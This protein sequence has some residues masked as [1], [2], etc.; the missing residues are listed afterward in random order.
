MEPSVESLEAAGQNGETRDG[1]SGQT[2]SSF[3]QYD[4]SETEYYGGEFE[5]YAPVMSPD[6]E[7]YL[8]KN[9]SLDEMAET[10]VDPESLYSITS[11]VEAFNVKLDYDEL[12]FDIYEDI[13]YGVVLAVPEGEDFYYDADSGDF[14]VNYQANPNVDLIYMGVAGDYSQ[15][16]F[17]TVIQDVLIWVPP[18]I[19]RVWAVEQFTI[20]QDFSHWIE[21]EGNRKIANILMVSED[22]EDPEFTGSSNI[23]LYITLLMGDDK[24]FMAIASYCMSD[25]QLLNAQQYGLDCLT[26]TSDDCDYFESLIKVFCAAH[27]TT[28]AY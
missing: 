26:Y 28:F 2:E 3:V 23:Y 11:Y 20:N 21:V 17:D 1:S 10:S 4:E 8:T 9:R 12:R 19:Q 5:E 25:T 27:L 13:N 24:A 7:F 15:T 14:H 22:F 6:F 16:D 18:I